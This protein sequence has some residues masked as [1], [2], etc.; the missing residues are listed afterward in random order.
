VK[1]LALSDHEEAQ[2]LG[3]EL[4][5]RLPDLESVVL[6]DWLELLGAQNLDV[7]S[8]V[9]E[10][11]ASVVSGTRLGLEQCVE[12]ALSPAAPLASL[13][14][15]WLLDKPISTPS[16]LAV[17]LRLGSAK[18][19]AVRG[20]AAQHIARLL[21]SLGFVEPMHVREMCDSP[22]VEVRGHGL[23][24]A[25]ERFA[26]QLPLWAALC[27]SPYVDVKSFVVTRAELFRSQAPETLAHIFGSL[28]LALSG[29][30]RDKRRVAREITERV[31]SEPAR[32]ETL[33][34]LLRITLSSVHPAEKS[35][36]LG[37]LARATH[38]HESLKSLVQ[39]K[40]PELTLS[41]R[42]SE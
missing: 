13:G 36:S 21:R 15:S 31:V 9:C 25:A 40:F 35:L 8:L 32:A 16:E 33:L 41:G 19:A 30:S 3:V 42:A 37:A 12:L 10:R 34:P 4:F 5:T 23:S 14:F 6:A 20:A 39:S 29:A 2:V 1:A 11:A 7:L 22:H 17:L 28:L 26:D 27:E 24:V 18:V 38:Q